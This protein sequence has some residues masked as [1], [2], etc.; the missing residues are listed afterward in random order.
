MKSQK[1]FKSAIEEAEKIV[2]AYMAKLEKPKENRILF[3]IGHIYVIKGGPNGK[4]IQSR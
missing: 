1:N 4:S 2:E 3:H